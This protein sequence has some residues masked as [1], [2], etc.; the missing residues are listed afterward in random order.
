MLTHNDLKRGTKVHLTGGREAIIFDN[1]KGIAR[2][3]EITAG[4]Y[5]EIGSTYVRD[6]T[7]AY[8]DGSWQIVH[9]SPAHKKKMVLVEA[10]GF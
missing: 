10:A 6:I 8:V 5:P 2:T 4:G 9:L 1:K 7:R 3:V